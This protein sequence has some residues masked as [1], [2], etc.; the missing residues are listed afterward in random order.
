MRSFKQHRSGIRQVRSAIS[1]HIRLIVDW[2]IVKNTSGSGDGLKLWKELELHTIL[3]ITHT[4]FDSRDSRCDD[5]RVVSAWL[6]P[7]EIG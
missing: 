3:Y 6:L 5:E 4:E 7:T 2:I 1:T